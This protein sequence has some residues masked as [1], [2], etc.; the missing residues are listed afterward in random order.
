M[1]SDL[2]WY[3]Q[4]LYLK[5]IR[6]FLGMCNLKRSRSS[7]ADPSG[8]SDMDQPEVPDLSGD[9]I[10]QAV[11]QYDDTEVGAA[12]FDFLGSALIPTDWNIYGEP[13]SWSTGSAAYPMSIPSEWQNQP[14]TQDNSVIG[15]SSGGNSI[16]DDKPN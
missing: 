7:S 11:D 1:V 13:I 5:S 9:T 15:S 14:E 16:T 10:D 2:F 12:I 4:V 8:E 3:L 6:N